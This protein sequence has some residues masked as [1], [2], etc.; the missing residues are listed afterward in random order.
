VSL[1]GRVVSLADDRDLVEIDRLSQHY[2]GAPYR[3]RERGRVS[4]WIEVSSWHA[5]QS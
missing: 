3:N 4:A 5:W 1:R 2:R